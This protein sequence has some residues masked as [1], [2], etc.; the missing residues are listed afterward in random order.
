LKRLAVGARWRFLLRFALGLAVLYF[1]FTNHPVNDR[2]VVVFTRGIVKVS[3]AMLRA[4]GEPVSAEG[5]TIRSASFAVDV[6]NGCNGLEAVI[7]LAAAILAFPAPAKMRVLGIVAGFAAIEALNL[8]RVVSLFWLGEHH[9]SAFE[10]AH[11]AVWQTLIILLSIGF[12]LLWSRRY[13]KTAR[14]ANGD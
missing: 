14:A 2:V 9:P 12:F 8:V 4:A 10:T 5:T 11:A 6:Q 7:L 1:A 13:G 3:A